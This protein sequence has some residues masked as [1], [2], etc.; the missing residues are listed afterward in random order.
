MISNQSSRMSITMQRTR[1][2]RRK[3]SSIRSRGGRGIQHFS[4]LNGFTS[5]ENNHNSRYFR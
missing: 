1:F 2:P 3:Q 4:Q 5:S